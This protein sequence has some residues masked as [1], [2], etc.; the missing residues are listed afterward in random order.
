MAKEQNWIHSE[1]GD[2]TVFVAFLITALLAISAL[3]VDIGAAYVKLSE[4]QNAADAAV[5]AAGAFLPA[6]K[7]DTATI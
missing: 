3:V 2:I 5:L 4:A 6:S 1:D 7:G